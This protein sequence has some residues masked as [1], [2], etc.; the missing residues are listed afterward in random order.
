MRHPNQ[1]T[2][3]SDSYDSP[4]GMEHVTV[5]DHAVQGSIVNSFPALV[6][7]GPGEK[8]ARA[9]NTDSGLGEPRVSAARA[10]ETVV[11]HATCGAG[12]EHGE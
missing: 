2:C 3:R 6:R 9:E 8:L 10:R 12:E 1:T 11:D 5:H 7:T 4:K